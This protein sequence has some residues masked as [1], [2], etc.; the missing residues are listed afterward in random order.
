[1]RCEIDVVI[2]NNDLMHFSKEL[3][4]LKSYEITFQFSYEDMTASKSVEKIIIDGTYDDFKEEV[5]NVWKEK[6]KTD[7]IK[8]VL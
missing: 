1:M 6:K 7:L 3:N 4:S 2:T 5:L 8:L